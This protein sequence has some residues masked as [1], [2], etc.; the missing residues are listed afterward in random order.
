MIWAEGVAEAV[1]VGAEA[2]G[3]ATI[4]ITTINTT[5]T[6]TTTTILSTITKTATIKVTTGVV[7]ILSEPRHLVTQSR[8]SSIRHSRRHWQELTNRI[9]GHEC[10]MAV[11]GSQWAEGSHKH[12][13]PAYPRKP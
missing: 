1:D 10:Q 4:T 8:Q 7:L 9:Q 13:R 2:E 11:V 12:W 5:T 6:T 3:V